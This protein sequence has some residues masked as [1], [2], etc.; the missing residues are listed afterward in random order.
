MSN[1]KQGSPPSAQK[2]AQKSLSTSHH[3]ATLN[4]SGANPGGQGGGQ[5]PN[6]GTTSGGGSQGTGNKGSRKP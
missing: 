2:V 3:T 6:S 1:N 4:P 5:Q